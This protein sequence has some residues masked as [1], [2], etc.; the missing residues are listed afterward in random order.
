[1]ASTSRYPTA[2]NLCFIWA[3]LWLVLSALSR[4]GFLFL[5]CPQNLQ[6]LEHNKHSI[7]TCWWITNESF[8]MQKQTKSHFHFNLEGTSTLY[9]HYYEIQNT[10]NFNL[11][12]NKNVIYFLKKVF[13]DKSITKR[14]IW[15]QLTKNK[16][17]ILIMSIQLRRSFQTTLTSPLKITKN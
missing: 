5:V 1:M 15:T 16:Q 3:Y 11:G 9:V 7:I 12:R 13:A 17:S 14:I 2:V 6:F 4:Q 8:R 10:I